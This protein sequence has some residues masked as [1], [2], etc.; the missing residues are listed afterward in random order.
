MESLNPPTISLVAHALLI[1]VGDYTHPRFA[2]LPAT[3]R[4]V[5]ALADIL[6][7]STR[8]GYPSDNVQVLT[9]KQATADNI[10]NALRVL[11]HSTTLESTV[12]VYFSGHGGRAWNDGQWHTYLCPREADAGSL[13][14]TAISGDEFSALLSAVPSRKLL[15]M[16][17]ACHAAGSAHFKSPDGVMVWKA[18]LPEKYYEVLAQ[19]AGRVIIASSREDQFSYV[20]PQ[21]DL[22]LFTYH[23][24]QALQ[25]RA[26]VRGDGL[27]HVLDV[28]HYINESVHDDEPRQTPILKVRDLDLNFPI[29]LAPG[30][31]SPGLTSIADDIASIRE[32]IIHDP[33]TGSK[34]LSEFLAAHPEYA[35]RQNEVDLKRAELEQIEHRLT[36][37]G[38]DPA[39]QAAK[40]RVVYFLLRLCL[41][42]EQTGNE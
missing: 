8:C 28:F 30:E 42:L 34:R 25:G 1:G 36:L 27:I 5:Q 10:R 22:S 11:A 26:A 20:R 19:G 4:D 35:A 16:L 18:G 3:V 24:V 9:G 29:A 41:E 6:T 23:L 39:E 40:N 17:D 31:K 12:L 14:Q 21:G 13:A 2:N 15:V 7:D 37:F 38:P 32:K 33:I